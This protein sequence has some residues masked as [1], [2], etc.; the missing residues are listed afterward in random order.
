MATSFPV[1]KC[2]A[3]LTL[4]KLPFPI[5]FSSYFPLINEQRL[6]NT[7]MVLTLYL[8]ICGSSPVLALW[9][10]LLKAP[11]AEA[12][13]TTRASSEDFF[14]STATDS[15]TVCRGVLTLAIFQS[16]LMSIDGKLMIAAV[17]DELMIE[18]AE[19][20]QETG[21]DLRRLEAD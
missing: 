12:S 1:G 10:R 11:E 16:L 9:E 13:L 5:V 6:Q 20:M 4:A 7:N 8:P 19:S 3:N 21:T 18:S 2:L 15:W 14:G 17:V